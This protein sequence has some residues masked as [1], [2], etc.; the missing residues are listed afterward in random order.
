MIPIS[1]AKLSGILGGQITGTDVLGGDKVITGVSTDSRTVQPGDCF[2]AIEGENFDGHDHIGAAFDCG[3]ICAV[4]QN[5]C[6]HF[7]RTVLKVDDTIE[8]MGDLAGWYRR[9]IRAKVI[10]ITG[11]A[12]KTTTRQI[13]SHVIGQHFSCRQSPKSFNN[14]IGLPLTIFS[15]KPDDEVL[16]T[17]IGANAPG[18]IACLTAIAQPDIAVVTN[19]HPAHLEGFGSIENIVKEKASISW[20]LC[21]GGVF[22]V[23]GDF[24]RL[25][26]H[27]DGVGHE[28]VSFGTTEDCDIRASGLKSKGHHGE[29]VIDGVKVVVPL[30]GKA[31]L[32]N[33]LAAWAICR[34]L[35]ISIGEF[36]EGIKTF[37]SVDMRLEIEKA[38]TVT[39]INDCYNANPASMANAV[40]C[41]GQLAANEGGRSVFVCGQM[42]E[43]GAHSEKLHVE[44]GHLSGAAGVGVLAA[45]G[46]YGEITAAAAKEKGNPDFEAFV[47]TDTEELCNNLVEIVRDDDII[48]V[49]GSRSAGLER[50]V[51]KLRELFSR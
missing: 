11:S 37:D 45:C 24:A 1:I 16:I 46:P 14:N 48:L 13:A 41:L 51:E 49:K 8:A 23:N 44:L 35:G 32:E 27:C 25:I 22:L 9:Q 36:A 4:S 10:A 20:G 2:F 29:L 17:E 43:L 15:T 38:G 39:I 33:T 34:Q 50:A 21:E 42:A 19:I 7:E 3:A 47:F 31:N 40:D 6:G 26:D 28:Y 5:D 30:A 12:G 18:E